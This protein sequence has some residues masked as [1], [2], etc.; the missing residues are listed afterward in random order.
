[1]SIYLITLLNVLNGVSLLNKNPNPSTEEIIRGMNRNL[2][3]CGAHPR[4]V[5]AIQTAAAEMKGAR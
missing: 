1:M 5:E 4:I 2:C 3:R